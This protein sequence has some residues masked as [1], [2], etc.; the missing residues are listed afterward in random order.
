MARRSCLIG[1]T[2]YGFVDFNS[3]KVWD[4][5]S[6]LL[7]ISN[8]KLLV[9]QG[10]HGTVVFSTCLNFVHLIKNIQ[11][12]YDILQSNPILGEGVPHMQSMVAL[13]SSISP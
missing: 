10:R 8:N 13:Y 7:P 11:L 1:F 12:T 4:I 2:G 9:V 5:P 6:E 3:E